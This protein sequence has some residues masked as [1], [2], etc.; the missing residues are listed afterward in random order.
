MKKTDTNVKNS[1]YKKKNNIAPKKQR[2]DLV[3]RI[4]IVCLYLKF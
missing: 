2:K 1:Y 4:L 3:N